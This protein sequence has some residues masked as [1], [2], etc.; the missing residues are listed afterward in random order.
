MLVDGDTELRSLV[1]DQLRRYGSTGTGL[2]LCIARDLAQ[3]SGGQIV[4]DN[5]P[6]GGLGAELKTP[7]V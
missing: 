3:R 5:R 1:A 2:R 6:E 7:P 4:L